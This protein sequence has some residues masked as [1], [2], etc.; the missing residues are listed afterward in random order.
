MGTFPLVTVRHLKD[1]AFKEVSF[2]SDKIELLEFTKRKLLSK[3]YGAVADIKFNENYTQDQILEL[4]FEMTN[5]ISNSWFDNEHINVYS[6]AKD[7]CRSSSI[8]DII[9]IDG[10]SFVVAMCGFIEIK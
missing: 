3:S 7:G 6:I 2:I 5:S 8:G 1:S 9:E 4:S 10:L